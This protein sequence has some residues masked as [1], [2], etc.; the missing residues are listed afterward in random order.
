M[1]AKIKSRIIKIGNSQGIRI[2]RPLLEQAGLSGE[3]EIEVRAQELIVHTVHTPRQGW[4]E[5][6][7][8]LA[9]DSDDLAPEMEPLTLTE[10]EANEWQW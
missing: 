3:V 8:L 10:W 4:E 1:A 6:Y 5:K 7:R 2:P 9:I